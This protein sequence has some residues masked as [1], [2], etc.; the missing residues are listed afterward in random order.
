VVSLKKSGIFSKKTCTRNTTRWSGIVTGLSKDGGRADFLK[1]SA[2]HSL[3][4]TYRMKLLPSRSILLDCTFRRPNKRKC[5]VKI[6]PK[7]TI[8]KKNKLNDGV[9]KYIDKYDNSTRSPSL[10]D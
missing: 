1:T 8:L 4:T 2:P 10:F 3:M 9:H 5:D 7:K 6:F